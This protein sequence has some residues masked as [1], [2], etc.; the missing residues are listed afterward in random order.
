MENVGM[1]TILEI[2]KYTLPGLIVFATAYSLLKLHLDDRQREFLRAQKSESSK[3]TLPLRLQAY[4]RLTL[5][6]DR[7]GIA[8]TLLRVRMPNMTVQE[9]KVAL[10]MAI[11]QEFDHNT[12]QQ[13][14]VSE[15]LWQI[16][17]FAKNE[18]LD[19]VQQA[20]VDLDPAADATILI[21]AIFK[22]IDLQEGMA[23]LPKA[24]T[25]IRTEASQFF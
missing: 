13:L 12:A 5:L 19:L 6:C 20:A 14:Y 16:I 10:L 21:D 18:T 1:E 25:A 15:T 23:P 8:N 3:I 24:L 7:I 2:S 9:L 4:E 17:T 11:S 22:R